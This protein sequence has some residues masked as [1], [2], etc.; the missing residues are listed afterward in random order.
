MVES[1]PVAAPAPPSQLVP[2]QSVG[3]FKGD[4]F[5]SWLCSFE[6]YCDQFALTEPERLKE[7]ES[8]LCDEARTWHQDMPF[9]SW[10]EWK[11]KAK[12]GSLAMDP[13]LATFLTR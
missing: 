4:G 11:V 6:D 2:S 9:K 13:T 1:A 7:V 5:C 10:E 3:F 12:N 8:L